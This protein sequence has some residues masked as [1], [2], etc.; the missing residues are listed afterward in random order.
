MNKALAIVATTVLAASASAL[1]AASANAND[2]FWSGVKPSFSSPQPSYEAPTYRRPQRE[3]SEPRASRHAE[4]PASRHAKP[5]RKTIEKEPEI[6]VKH[7]D[8]KGREYDVASKV[9]FDGKNNCWT[10]KQPWV[11]KSGSWF[12]GNS[13]WH[14]N[15]GAW[16]T[17]AAD[18]PAPVDCRSNAVFAAKMPAQPEDKGS[19]SKDT[20][21]SEGRSAAPEEK[22][23][24]DSDVP[25]PIRTAE[26]PTETS[27]KPLPPQQDGTPSKAPDCKKYSSSIG[28]MVSVPCAQ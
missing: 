9:W 28:G 18:D 21:Y 10:G 15:D 4:P 12:Y 5:A 2:R 23:V 19:N 25:P 7:T 3:Y 20:Q 14:L 26:K 11:F 1:M 16:Q 17:N 27:A 13:R 8:G 6:V 24:S 22:K